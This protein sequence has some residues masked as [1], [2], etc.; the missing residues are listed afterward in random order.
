MKTFVFLSLYASINESLMSNSK[1]SSYREINQMYSNQ[2]NNKS[3]FIYLYDLD[4]V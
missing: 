1:H 4:R 2:T 3:H